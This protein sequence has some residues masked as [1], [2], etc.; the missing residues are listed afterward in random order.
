M[1]GSGRHCGPGREE[2]RFLEGPPAA[3]SIPEAAAQVTGNGEKSVFN[4]KN[5][6][7]PRRSVTTG[8]MRQ[9]PQ[10]PYP[11]RKTR[12]PTQRC[13]SL[14]PGFVILEAMLIASGTPSLPHP[15]D[16]ATS[17]LP[18]E[19]SGYGRVTLWAEVRA[20][21][22]EEVRPEPV[23]IVEKGRKQV[24][25]FKIP[26]RAREFCEQS[27]HRTDR[28]KDFWGAAGAPCGRQPETVNARVRQGGVD[29]GAD[30]TR[31]TAMWM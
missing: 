8:R 4:W 21:L 18:A 24:D 2:D 16:D 10:H 13:R 30:C 15:P 31:L 17:E 19:H 7:P 26:F 12:L 22:D 6:M 23:L 1:I 9:A 27:V 20:I 14:T 28:G 3:L 5:P 29:L 11:G 25:E